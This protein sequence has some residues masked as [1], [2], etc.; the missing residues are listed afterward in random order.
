MTY[1][2]THATDEIRDELMTRYAITAEEADTLYEQAIRPELLAS[3][4]R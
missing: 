2:P 1:I 3:E 4:V